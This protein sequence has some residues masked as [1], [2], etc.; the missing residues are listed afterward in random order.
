MNSRFKILK[1]EIDQKIRHTRIMKQRIRITAALTLFISLIIISCESTSAE[2][3]LV[4]IESCTTP[5]GKI[6][7][8]ADINLNIKNYSP[9]ETYFISFYSLKGKATISD[10]NYNVLSADTTYKISTSEIRIKYTAHNN[11]DH[12]IEFI[13]ETESG[14]SVKKSIQITITE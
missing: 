4:V 5:I 10:E 9:Q 3:K 13:I 7:E 2:D 6:G 8:T 1:I 11:G 12:I 14:M